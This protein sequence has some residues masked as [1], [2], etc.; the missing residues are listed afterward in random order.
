[1]AEKKKERPLYRKIVNGFMTGV[2]V[3]IALA[4]IAFGF[5]Q[6][7]T[8]HNYLKNEIQNRVNSSIS[9]KL[10]IG[11]LD[12]TV[13]T[14]L[15][16]RDVCVSANSD[17]LLFAKKIESVLNPAQLALN[18]IYLRKIEIEDVLVNL[19]QD[20]TN[21][22]NIDKLLTKEKTY[23]NT[24]DISNTPDSIDGN[25]PYL[26]QIVSAKLSNLKF[27]RKSNE[28]RDSSSVMK[29]FNTDNLIIDSVYFGFSLVADLNRNEF[30]ATLNNL[31]ANS[32]FGGFKLRELSGLLHV[33]DSFAEVKGLKLVTG[34]SAISINARLDS[35]NLFAPVIYKNFK[36]FPVK[37]DLLANSF[38]FD[39]LSSFLE[40]TKILSGKADLELALEGLYGGFDIKKLLLNYGDSQF[41]IIGKMKNLNIPEH[42]YMDLQF[43]QSSAGM[44]DVA[45]LLP[46]TGIPTFDGLTLNDFNGIYKG[47]PTDFY[48][49]IRGGVDGGMI[50]TKAKLNVAESPMTYDISA[51]SQNLDIQKIIGVPTRINSTTALKGKGTSPAEI[52]S[53]LSVKL[54]D[55]QVNGYSLDSLNLTAALL[56]R[57]FNLNF[58]GKVNDAQISSRGLLEFPIDSP[59][60]YNLTGGVKSLDIS[61]FT[62]DSTTFSSLNFLYDFNGQSFKLDSM[63]GEYTLT[64]APSIY[65]EYLLD[66][67]EIKL[68]LKSDSLKKEINL[69]S[70]FVDVNIDGDFSLDE[71]IK[72]SSYQGITISQIIG[73]KIHELNPLNILEEDTTDAGNLIRIPDYTFNDLYVNYNFNFKDFDIIGKVIGA[74]KLNISGGGEGTIRNDSANFSISTRVDLDYLIDHSENTSFYI[75]GVHADFDF[76]RRNGSQSFENFFGSLS[77]NGKRI[78]TGTELQDISAD[79][80]FNGSKIF[81]NNSFIADSSLSTQFDGIIFMKPA[82]QEIVFENFDVIYKDIDWKLREPVSLFFNPTYLNLY[83]LKLF[84]NDASVQ[85]NGYIRSSGVQDV[86]VTIDDLPA[87]LLGNYFSPETDFIAGNIEAYAQMNGTLS[88]P[89][90]N[91]HLDMFN[92]TYS[93]VPFGALYCD[94]D[95]SNKLMNISLNF[96]DSTSSGPVTL[97][98]LDGFIPID[99]SLVDAGERLINDEDLDLQLYSNKLDIE[100]FADLLPLIRDQRGLLTA[101][102]DIG[103][104]YEN[105]NYDGFLSVANDSFVARANN[106][107][108]N[109]G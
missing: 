85:F 29:Y 50:D 10:T 102:V 33:T 99:L 87:S 83:G 47:E 41:D 13:F 42:L 71:A 49:E 77:F 32:N 109:A 20:S 80:V 79:L 54:Y 43:N 26:I 27:I 36:E 88:D 51:V 72:I 97:I 93:G 57:K 86:F 30:A 6:T 38:N 21:R 66:E 58:E 104:N 15:I 65:N 76:N 61:R 64:L 63:S 28:F 3:I 2:V 91:A 53:D 11:E 62:D 90:I 46:Q 52:F 34:R 45:E 18:K 101:D 22:W 108:Y 70:R 7:E 59:P 4:L 19:S 5:S 81:F 55:S 74:E 94:A 12:G 89:I 37:L 73:D 78:Y 69:T 44:R 60:R 95:Y 40:A 8:F 107:T 67:S 1:M 105:I 100:L 9:G 24:V 68:L 23:P 96:I 103:G 16:L 82:E 84:H 75:S 14:S 106:L 35:L 48:T 31:S 56:K 92:V 25:F 17:T 98:K 39:D